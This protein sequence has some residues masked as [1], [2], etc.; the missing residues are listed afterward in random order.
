MLIRA[1]RAGITVSAGEL[2][3]ETAKALK[4]ARQERD[5]ALHALQ[6]AQQEIHTLRSRTTWANTD[7]EA[8]PS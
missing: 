6:V 4:Q 5:E 2:E 1:H 3:E 7:E 8:G